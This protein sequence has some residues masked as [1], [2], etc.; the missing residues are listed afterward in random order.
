VIAGIA[1]GLSNQ[2]I[3]RRLSVSPRTVTTHVENIL[4]RL[5]LASRSAVVRTALSHGMYLMSGTPEQRR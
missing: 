2:E 4:V 3:A 1:D 5:G